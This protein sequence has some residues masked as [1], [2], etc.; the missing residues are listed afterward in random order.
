MDVM[1]IGAGVMGLSTA[2]LLRESDFDA[3]IVASKPP[4][5]T[6]S[7]VAA[8][9]WYPYKAS[10]EDRI[11]GW[12]KQ[13]YD[14]FEELSHQP[15]TGIHMRDGLELHYEPA[16]PPFWASAVP[17][18]RRVSPD[19][20]P[21]G[22][23]DGYAFAVPVI[24][25]PIYLRYLVQR[26]ETI[27]GSIEY[28]EVELVESVE[29]E[30]RIIVNCAGLGAR[31]LVGDTTTHPIRGQIVRVQNPGLTDFILD[32]ENPEGVTYIIPR[33]EDCILGGI[34][35]ENAW[36]TKPDP[37]VAEGILSRCVGLEPRLAK[38]E[39]LEHKVG[40]RP[41]RP[42]IR[43]ET[44]ELDDGTACVHNYGHGGSGITL[45]WGCAAETADLV[46]RVSESL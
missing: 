29:Q 24:E 32:D 5:E 41:G 21:P 14:V 23:R 34:A 7:S 38:A 22:R 46:K 15:E 11:I 27:G 44:E 40:L 31:D 25:M 35:E 42:E 2:I 45:S 37:K 16:Q 26:F 4:L 12:G 18:V 36:E 9:I 10:P 1:V 8:A 43:L 3:H 33:S 28:R 39:I 13:A 19:E 6:T 20:L 17:N 30:A